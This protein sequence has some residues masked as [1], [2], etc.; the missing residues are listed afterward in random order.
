MLR[1]WK[2]KVTTLEEARVK[3]VEK[4]QKDADLINELKKK[5]ADKENEEGDVQEVAWR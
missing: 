2:L 4:M 5:L 1:K 3:N